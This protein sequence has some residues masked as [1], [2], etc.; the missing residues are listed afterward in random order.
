MHDATD[1]PNRNPITLDT[2]RQR[3]ENVR[4]LHPLYITLADAAKIPPPGRRGRPVHVATILRWIVDGTPHPTE[5]GVRVYLQAV[6][7]GGR[8]LTTR[9]WMDEYARRLTPSYGGD[10]APGQAANRRA[11]ERDARELDA[12]GI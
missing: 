11:A 6:R 10:G 2:A 12:I 9:E 8:W 1:L 5:E 3:D 7:M 4:P